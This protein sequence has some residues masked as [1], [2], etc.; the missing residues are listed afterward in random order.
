MQRWTWRARDLIPNN[1]R[2][3]CAGSTE[4]YARIYQQSQIYGKAMEVARKGN[5]DFDTYDIVIKYMQTTEIKVDKY[6]HSLQQPENEAWTG[7]GGTGMER[8]N[9]YS[10]SDT[11]ANSANRY[12]ASGSCAG[13]SDNEV[14]NIKTPPRPIAHGRPVGKRFLSFLYKMDK[15][16]GPKK[17]MSINVRHK[18]ANTVET[19]KGG[20]HGPKQGK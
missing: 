14:M 17:N 10:S 1:L 2:V 4:E 20:I 13:M 18:H 3:K 15:K 9:N 16:R 6:L 7:A 8:L 11:E 19:T 12:G 5:Y